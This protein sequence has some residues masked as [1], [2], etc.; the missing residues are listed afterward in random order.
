MSSTKRKK[1][2]YILFDLRNSQDAHTFYIVNPS[3]GEYNKTTNIVEY[4]TSNN[5]QFMRDCAD[6]LELGEDDVTK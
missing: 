1:D 5:F 6:E 2:Y 4:M 3:S